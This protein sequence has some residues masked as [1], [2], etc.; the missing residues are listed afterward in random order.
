[1][2]KTARKAPLNHRKPDTFAQGTEFRASAEAI[3]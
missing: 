1:M 2:G 3:I